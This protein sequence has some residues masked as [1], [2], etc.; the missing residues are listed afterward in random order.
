MF[1]FAA[2]PHPG[3]HRRIFSWLLLCLLQACTSTEHLVEA[4]FHGY[5]AIIDPYDISLHKRS[6]HIFDPVDLQP[7]LIEQ[8]LQQ[9]I[10]HLFVLIDNS[11]SMNEEYRGISKTLYAEEILRRFNKTL[12]PVKLNGEVMLFSEGWSLFIDNLTLPS[13]QYDR[14]IVANHLNTNQ[15]FKPSKGAT[16]AE[17]LDHLTEHMGRLPG[18]SAV[19]LITEWQRIDK[20]VIEAVSRMRQRTK[21]SVGISVADNVSTWNGK[22]GDGACLYTIGVGNE[23]SR[24]RFDSVDECGFSVAAD[25]VAQP[26][27]MAHFVERILFS[28]PKDSD[29]DGIFD[30]K[31]VCPNTPKNIIVDFY[32]CRRFTPQ[33]SK[34]LIPMEPVRD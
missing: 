24:A 18:R 15:H 11:Q 8:Q 23:M 4:E 19:V 22:N 33:T 30:Y 12:P 34:V 17:S 5:N 27:D 1:I 16:L 3:K 28:G 26:R 31:D 2:I 7:K 6:I 25:R 32:G 21:Y 9:K 10:D 14:A 20:S 29:N 13:P